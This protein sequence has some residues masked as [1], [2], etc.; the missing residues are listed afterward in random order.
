MDELFEFGITS[1][2]TL[3]W[4]AGLGVVFGL[5]GRLSPCNPGMY[6][7]T[8]LRAV[9]A[10]LVY[11]FIVPVFTRFGRLV[12]LILGIALL[13]GGR[14]PDVLPVRHRSLWLQC[15]AILVLQDVLLYWL[16]RAFHT[17]PAWRFHAVHHSPSTLDWMSSGRNHPINTLFSTSLADVAVLLLGFSPEAIFALAPFQIAYS[18]LV[19]ANL[20][21]TY[22]PLRFV[23]ASPVF[24]RW[25]HTTRAEGIDKNFAPTF[26]LLDVVFGTFYM[27]PGR[28]PEA[29]GSGDAAL[30]TGFWGQ[31]FYPFRRGVATPTAQPPA[32]KQRR[33]AA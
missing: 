27:P 19:H 20:N 2:K 4:L 14:D 9:A 26:P 31:F 1:L 8:D 25:H 11:W 3:G 10:D 17:R 18:A 30:P 33:R 21:W 28:L 24:H 32:E 29:Y 22:G 23:L 6:W 15:A 12:L 7:W 13:F 16:H 5:L